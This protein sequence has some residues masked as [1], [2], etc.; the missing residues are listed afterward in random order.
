MN[1]WWNKYVSLKILTKLDLIF[2]SFLIHIFCW[3]HYNINWAITRTV[4]QSHW[5]SSNT[6]PGCLCP[7]CVFASCR[8]A[9]WNIT[10]ISSPFLAVTFHVTTVE[11]SNTTVLCLTILSVYHL[12]P[13]RVIL[14]R[15]SQSLWSR[16]T[17]FYVAEFSWTPTGRKEKWLSCLCS[18]FLCSKRQNLLKVNTQKEVSVSLTLGQDGG[19]FNSRTCVR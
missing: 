18:V 6:H 1:S 10:V 7:L 8:M 12:H 9:N 15:S 2:K 16:W 5:R 4:S 13:F 17:S 11:Y 3:Q 19:F 14:N